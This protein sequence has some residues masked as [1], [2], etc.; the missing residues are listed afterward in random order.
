MDNN[1]RNN[2]NR[3]NSDKS[4]NRRDDLKSNSNYK[5]PFNGERK[6]GGTSSPKPPRF[7]AQEINEKKVW[8]KPE[9]GAKSWETDPEDVKEFA[10][11]L[12]QEEG[13]AA[14]FKE[15]NK[16]K[17]NKGKGVAQFSED[18]V[19]F[20]VKP[21]KKNSK[22]NFRVAKSL[23]DFDDDEIAGYEKFKKGR[24]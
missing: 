22:P 7:G 5:R 23:D 19:P 9:T 13:R 4:Y 17:F 8:K 6:E 11:D 1:N 10:R 24:K 3:H 2:N 16:K 20:N 12:G 14:K 15:E 21:V 18:D